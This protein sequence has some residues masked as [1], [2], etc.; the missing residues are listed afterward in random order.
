MFELLGNKDLNYKIFFYQMKIKYRTDKTEK[1][2]DHYK[3]SFQ[4]VAL[5]LVKNQV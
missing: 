4:Q 5:I 2:T 3:E 1:K